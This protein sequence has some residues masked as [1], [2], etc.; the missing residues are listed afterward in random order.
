MPEYKNPQIAKGVAAN[1]E[2]NRIFDEGTAA[3]HQSDDYI[4]TT[5]V[6]ATV[7]F[8]LALSQRFRRVVRFGL[9]VPAGG[10]MIYALVTILSVPRLWRSALVAA[11]PRPSHTGTVTNSSRLQASRPWWRQRRQEPATLERAVLHYKI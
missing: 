2:A 5:V 6:R 4:R 7:L 1:H 11:S 8:L 3:R 10:L 9:L